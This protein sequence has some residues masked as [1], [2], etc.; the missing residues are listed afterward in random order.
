RRVDRRRKFHDA[1]LLFGSARAA[2]ALHDVH[3]V[4]GDAAGLQVDLDDLPFL[5]LVVAAHDAHGVTLGHV[6]LHALRVVRVALAVD[7]ARPVR[8]AVLVDSHIKSPRAPMTRSSYTA[9]RAARARP[10]RRYG[11]PGAP[12]AR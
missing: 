5:A 1:A 12:L 3:A 2:V 7:R 4:H 6:Q 9:S 8:L 10:V 11:S